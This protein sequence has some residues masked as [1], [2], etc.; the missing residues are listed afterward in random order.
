[1]TTGKEPTVHLRNFDA[2]QWPKQRAFIDSPAK[3]KIAKAGRRGAKTTSIGRLATERFLKGA[4][5]LYGA[6]TMDQVETFWFEVKRAL[7]EPI[8]HKL[9]HK[10]ESLH[11]IDLPGTKQRIRAKTAW[12]ADTLRGDYADL[13]IL[14]EWQLMDEDAWE[15]VGAPMLLDNDG[16]AVF[17]YTPPSLHSRSIS[18]ARDPQHAARMFSNAEADETG[19]WEVFHWTSHDNPA[20]SEAG[21]ARITSDMTRLAYRQ[22]ILA[23][24]MDEVPG[25]LWTR[26]TIEASRVYA[27]RVPEL[28]RLVVGV[29]PPGGGTECGIVA[30]GVGMCDCKG[31]ELQRHAFVMADVSV[32]ASPGIWADAVIDLYHRLQAG[33]VVGEKNYGGDMVEHTIRQ[34]ARAR[35]DQISYKNVNATRGKAVRAEPIAA[36]YEQGRVHHVG[37]LAGLED[38]Q[39]TWVPGSPRSPNRV[40]ACVWALTELQLG[41]AGIGVF[42]GN[43]ARMAVRKERAEEEEAK[44]RGMVRLRAVSR[45]RYPA[46][47]G[48]TY[49]FEEGEEKN[50]PPEVAAV[51]LEIH[52]DKFD[53]VE[54]ETDLVFEEDPALEFEVVEALTPTQR[55]IAARHGSLR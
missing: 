32:K 33:R 7:E 35:A 40:D 16:D 29:D 55:K 48:I 20:I 50:V 15:V 37:E 5:V 8:E 51:L 36:M 45:H 18:K 13:L 44:M 10:N 14:D 46:P 52:P 31:G 54:I 17:I 42:L 28:S 53:K 11:I 30:A 21:L 3:R 4:R 2:D 27:S 41:P 9:F 12:N 25:A 49:L 1:M 23:E 38:E 19:L 24:D 34:A 26:A 47:D 39:V 6:P 43:E 22:E